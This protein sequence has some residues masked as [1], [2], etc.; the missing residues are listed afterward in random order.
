[1]SFFTGKVVIITGS[2]NGIDRGTAVLFAKEGAKVT[3]TG[4]NQS[5]LEETK[6]LCLTAGAKSEDILEV[7]GDITCEAFNEQLIATTVDKF[8]RLDV[9]VNNA[10]GASFEA[11]G[12]PILDVPLADF[13]KMIDL[14]VKPV[15]RLSKFATPHLE[16]TKGSIINVSSIVAQLRINTLAF[17]A[18]AKSTLDQITVQMARS[19]IKRGIRVNSVNPGPVLTNFIAT[20]GASQEQQAK[21]YESMANNPAIPLGRIGV[22]EDIGHIII[23]LADRPKSEILVGNIITADGGYMLQRTTLLKVD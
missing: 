16:K 13:D 22:P 9:L 10:G 11:M 15:I 6:Q 23:F 12:K 4:R 20:A 3:I 17:Y 21:A 5:A 1:M 7:I 2:S 19:L 8:S 18:A 14:N